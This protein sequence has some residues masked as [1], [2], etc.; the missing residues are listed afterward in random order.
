MFTKKEIITYRSIKVPDELCKKI[1][2]TQKRSDKKL[3]FISA[4]AACF[5][6][7]I[8]GFLINNQSNICTVTM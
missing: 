4:V 6:F 5:I 7:I 1:A 2:K 8:S 3:Y